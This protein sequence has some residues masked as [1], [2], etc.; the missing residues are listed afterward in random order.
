[1]FKRDWGQ[2]NPELVNAF[3][4]ASYEAKS[5]LLNSDEEW[6]ALRPSMHDMDQPLFEELRHGYRRGVPR[7][8]SESDI[9]AIDRVARIVATGRPPAPA[10]Q[11]AQAM[12]PEEIF[13]RR[14][15][16]DI[17]TASDDR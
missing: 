2:A 1:M 6:Q 16:P 9:A 3:L 11:S 7:H 8:F 15:T 12:L 17:F 5:L 10:S 14:F 13:W 4:A